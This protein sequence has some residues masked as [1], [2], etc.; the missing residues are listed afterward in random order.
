MTLPRLGLLK[1]CLKCLNT[2]SFDP[3]LDVDLSGLEILQLT[4][5]GISA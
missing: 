2:S 5:V 1:P 3:F 4:G